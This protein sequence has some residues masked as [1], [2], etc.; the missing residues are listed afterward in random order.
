MN[1]ILNSQKD[2]TDCA[3]HCR[4]VA[5]IQLGLVMTPQDDQPATSSRIHTAP[6]R[7]GMA[8][9]RLRMATRIRPTLK[10]TLGL[11]LNRGGHRMV[12]IIHI[13]GPGIQHAQRTT[14]SHLH[15]ALLTMSLSRLWFRQF[16]TTRLS[17]HLGKHPFTQNRLDLPS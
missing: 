12:T 1:R 2:L 8:T 16:L 17:T 14:L 9:D 3:F 13:D 15:H 4:T 6:T 5:I 10:L 7:G 11:Q